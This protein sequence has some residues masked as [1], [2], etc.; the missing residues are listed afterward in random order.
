MQSSPRIRVLVLQRGEAGAQNTGYVARIGRERK[1]I[2]RER[3]VLTYLV[4]GR[5]P[6]FL[7]HAVIMRD[8]EEAFLGDRCCLTGPNHRRQKWQSKVVDG[9]IFGQRRHHGFNR[10]HVDRWSKHWAPTLER[11]DAQQRANCVRVLVV[12]ESTQG[13]R[14]GRCPSAA[15]GTAR[16]ARRDRAVVAG[17]RYFF[18]RVRTFNVA[19]ARYQQLP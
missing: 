9:S 7:E 13:H 14:F 12:R 5:K 19:D 2:N 6:R 11:R 8:R 17:R 18:A 3:V 15:R 4:I 16:H 10:N 1:L